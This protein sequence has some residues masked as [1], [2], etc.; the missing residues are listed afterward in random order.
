M[1]RL[2][3]LDCGLIIRHEFE[4]LRP[5]WLNLKG[6]WKRY[7]ESNEMVETFGFAVVLYAITARS[8]LFASL[9]AL[10]RL[11]SR[12]A[13]SYTAR[14]YRFPTRIFRILITNDLDRRREPLLEGFRY[15]DAVGRKPLRER[16]ADLP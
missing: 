2:V 13:G 15:K 3:W 12:R 8:C 1:T 9:C 7:R 4:T 16:R 5:A 11:H 10:S 6:P 14:L